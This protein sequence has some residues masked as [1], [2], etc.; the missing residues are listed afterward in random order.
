VRLDPRY[1]DV[2]ASIGLCHERTGDAVNA[3]KAYRQAVAIDPNYDDAWLRLRELLNKQKR[4]KEADAAAFAAVLARPANKAAWSTVLYGLFRGGVT[5][6]KFDIRPKG[7]YSV[8]LNKIVVD[9]GLNAADKAAWTAVAEAQQAVRDPA[10]GHKPFAALLASWDSALRA[11]AQIDKATPVTDKYLRN[12]LAFQQAGQLKAALF[13][14]HFRE[15]YRDDYE[16]WKKA[17]P[18]GLKRFIDTFH[19]GL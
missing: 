9:A 19:L 3:E 16:A 1:A 5:A 10:Y 11:I 7:S 18:D 15:D 12:M 6:S 4:Y 2:H 8:R 13:A 17:E 14:L